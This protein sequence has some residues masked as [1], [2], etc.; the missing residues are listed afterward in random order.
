TSIRERLQRARESALDAPQVGGNLLRLSVGELMVRDAV[1]ADVAMNIR[2]AARLMT[3]ERVS[4]LL[5]LRDG[6]LEG[7]V[8]D[9]DLRIR[10]VAEDR[11]GETPL[12][13]IMTPRPHTI[14]RSSSAFE[15][16]MA[17]SRLRIH[18][19][20][21]VDRD[22]VQGL[23]S[24]NDLLRAQ[25]ANPLYLADRIRRC[26][27][28]GDLRQVAGEA[29]ELQVQ[30]VAAHASARQLG[31]ALTSVCD[32][33]TR[34]LIELSIHRLG[35]PPV[36]FAW[37]ATGSQG[38]GELTLHSDQDN[39]IILDDDYQSDLHGDYFAALAGEVNQG[40][41]ASG[42]ALCPGDV[43]A[44]NSRWRQP[45][46]VWRGYFTEWLEKTDH[47]A[48]TLA[49]NFLDM[50]TVWG[51]DSLR[52]R[53]V[54]Q[55]LPRCRD[56]KVFLAYMASHALG[57]RPPLG[58]FRNFVLVG[59]GEHEGAVDLKRHGLLPI[60]D[61]ARV[62]ALAGGVESVATLDRLEESLAAGTL[63]EEGAENLAAAFEF[64]SLIRS[65]H[66]AQQLRSG[67][68]VDNYVKPDALTAMERRH[69]KDAFAAIATLQDSVR[70]T[71]GDRLPR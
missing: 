36:H 42:Y 25:S 24:T 71:H 52:Q 14:Q 18:H 37:V 10:V 45:L 4:S 26:G 1:T 60:V 69:L 59:S 22:G 70:A 63:S 7:I 19:L 27:S 51:E 32:A 12:V 28:V 55:V 20:P 46:A 23:V 9:R 3:R 8:T 31:Q 5:V 30:M 58:F 56:D 44:S 57:N 43:M 2:D 16:L 15:A 33:V 48:A 6:A 49:V 41:G 47:K 64:I 34:R 29:R 66:Q 50:R 62:Y 39:A 21:V 11:S 65:K 53:L 13:E 54:A 40:L 38:R 61:L 35:E 68:E 17:M 67:G